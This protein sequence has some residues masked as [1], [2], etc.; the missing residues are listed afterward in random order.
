MVACAMMGGG[1]A[2]WSNKYQ[3]SHWK[4]H[5]C[6]SADYHPRVSIGEGAWLSCT[7][8]VLHVQDVDWFNP[9]S[10][11]SKFYHST[12]FYPVLHSN[13]S[14]YSYFFHLYPLW[15]SR[16]CTQSSKVFSHRGADQTLTVLPSASYWSQD[17]VW[18]PQYFCNCML[19]HMLLTLK[20]NDCHAGP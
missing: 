1:K 9:E 14:I 19:W 20:A 3:F 11:N 12:H 4:I 7:A 17:N 15:N 10:S 5:L 8:H 2:F 13:N 18:K 16:K 6:L